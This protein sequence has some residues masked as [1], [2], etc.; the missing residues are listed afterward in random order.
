MFHH[1]V[2]YIICPV[3]SM[4]SLRVLPSCSIYRMPS[5]VN[6]ILF[7]TSYAQFSQCVHC[8]FH[9]LAPYI[10][11]PVRRVLIFTLSAT[12]TMGCP[13]CGNAQHKATVWWKCIRCNGKGWE[14]AEPASVCDTCSGHGIRARDQAKDCMDCKGSGYRIIPCLQHGCV[15]GK[16]PVTCKDS[17]YHKSH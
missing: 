1:L 3:Q 14:T 7:D 12:E 10:I 16:Q 5:S 13:T 2:R 17:E 11:C 4:C 6:V 8:M 15:R 9:H